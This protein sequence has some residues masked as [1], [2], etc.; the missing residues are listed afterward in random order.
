VQ[1]F[2]NS[3]VSETSVYLECSYHEIL[4]QILARGNVKG[5][6]RDE[7][8]DLHDGFDVVFLDFYSMLIHPPEGFVR[9]MEDL[10]FGSVDC[11]DDGFRVVRCKAGKDVY[12]PNVL[13]APKFSPYR[14]WRNVAPSLSR[15]VNKLF[16]LRDLGVDYLINID[17]TVPQEVSLSWAGDVDKGVKLLKSAFK[18]FVKCLESKFHGIVGGFYNVHVWSTRN[19]GKA[20]FHVHSVFC[21]AVLKDDR[22]I[23]F[24]PYFDPGFIREIWRMCLE[25]VGVKVDVVDVHVS[26]IKLSNHGAVV[27]RVKYMS[28]HPLIDIASY[29]VNHNYNG[30][31]DGLRD[32]YLKLIYY[33]NRRV[34]G[35]FLRKL[36]KLVGDVDVKHVCPICGSDSDDGGVVNFVDVDGLIKRFDD[37]LLVVVFW[38]LQDRRYKMV[39]SDKWLGLLKWVYPGSYG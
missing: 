29:Y 37:G 4:Q 11:V 14:K 27:H 21:N 7:L 19:P 31:D 13:F 36:S 25:S 32:W 30:V 16:K 1:T 6:S 24:R 28:R 8:Q 26:Y 15:F 17:L 23:R 20:H 10:G 2:I 35:G 3:R 12:V 18:L 9:L 5:V 34:C 33:V 38:D 22:F 39:Y